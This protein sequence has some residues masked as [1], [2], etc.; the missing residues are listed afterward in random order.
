METALTAA[1]VPLPEVVP[2]LAALLSLPLPSRYP[3]LTLTPQ[4]Q[5]EYTLHA[6]LTVLLALAAQRPVLFIVEDLHW[7]DPSTLDLLNLLIDQGPTARILTV[8]A[9]RPEFHPP[10]PPRAH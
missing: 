8:L 3:A 6:I 5:K 9:C 2:L 10:W 1:A 7:V 4:R